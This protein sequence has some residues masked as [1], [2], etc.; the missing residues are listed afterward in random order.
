MRAD[1][2]M[3]SW[4]LPTDPT[5][6]TC[7]CPCQAPGLAEWTGVPQLMDWAAAAFLGETHH[8]GPAVAAIYNPYSYTTTIGWRRGLHR[9]LLTC[10]FRSGTIL[11]NCCPPEQRPWAAPLH[12]KQTSVSSQDTPT[13]QS[14]PLCIDG[15]QAKQPSCF[16]PTHNPTHQSKQHKTTQTN[17]LPVKKFQ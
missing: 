8:T 1:C 17:P 2:R 15:T 12:F 11:K 9:L 14:Q 4:L 13:Q 6:W 3:L 10:S 7:P 5:A 16:N